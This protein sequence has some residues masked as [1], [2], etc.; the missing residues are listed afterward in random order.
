MHKAFYAEY[1]QIEDRHWWFIG[2]R[3]IFL[4]VLDK[5]LPLSTPGA[6]RRVLDVG[7]G[8]G[9]MLGYLARYGRAEGID[10]DK[11]AVRFC[12]ERGVRDVHHVPALPLPFDDATFDLVTAFDVLEHI[13]D[14]RGMLFELER[15]LRPAGTLFVSVPAYQF[16]WGAQDEISLHERRYVA[17]QLRERIVRAGFVARRLSYF[18]TFLFPIVAGVRLARPYRPGTSKLKSDFT[19]TKPGLSNTLLA[20]LFALEAPLL[21]RADLPFGVSILALAHKPGGDGGGNAVADTNVAN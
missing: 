18:N 8:T 17:G 1:F 9:T 11:E 21:A 20:R 13:N 2:R 14:D 6:E 12:H 5:Y 10:A 4:T 15:V 3:Q 7:C 19:L 16:L